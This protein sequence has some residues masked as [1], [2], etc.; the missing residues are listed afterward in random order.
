MPGPHLT[1]DR[2][3]NWRGHSIRY[4]MLGGG[5]APPVFLLHGTPFNSQVWRRVAPVLADK[6]RVIF[7]D[8]L[9]YGESDKPDADVSL[10][11]QNGVFAALVQELGVERPD[12]IA[13]DFGGATALRAHLLDALEYNS[14]LLIDP[15]AVRPWGSPFVQHVREHEAAFAGM[16]A[17]MHEALLRA[18]LASSAACALTVAALKIYCAPWLG[19][20]GQ[21][22]YYRQ[23]AQM[24]Q[25]Y[26]DEVEGAYGSIRCPLHILWGELDTWIPLEHGKR[27]AAMTPQRTLQPIPGAG[28]LVQEDRPEVIVSAAERHL[29]HFSPV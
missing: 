17:Y 15:V 24:D 23:I 16:P 3:F 10:G 4:G 2:S 29:A 20:A 8:L 14:L 9:G 7:H 22:G 21:R 12:V 13:H 28:H 27:F 11:V 19:D 5:D 18:Y 6:R 25:S 1:L 26:T